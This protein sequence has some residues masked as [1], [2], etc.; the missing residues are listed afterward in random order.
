M[1]DRRFDAEASDKGWVT[2]ITSIRTHGRFATPF[3]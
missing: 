3:G 2:D 1:L